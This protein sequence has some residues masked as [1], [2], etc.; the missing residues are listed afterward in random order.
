MKVTN[1]HFQHRKHAPF[2]FKG[3][4]F[5]LEPGKLHALHGKNG[6][7][8]SVLLNILSQNIEQE[9]VITGEIF[10]TSP[11]VLMNQRFDQAL[12]GQFTAL[13]NLAFARF[14]RFPSLFAP[15]RRG[16]ERESLEHFLEPFHIEPHVPV[17]N[18]SGGQRQ[19][20]TLLMQLQRETKV[21]L[22]DEPTAALDEE[23]AILV[24]EFLKTLRD[25]TL[26]V[27][28]HDRELVTKYTTGQHLQME[29]QGEGLRVIYQASS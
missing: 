29:L 13:E 12:A 15:L 19:I 9:A 25:V 18:L 7:G 6:I 2:F 20:L 14:G 23:N 16:K 1:L 26:L 3:L 11:A 5:Q 24:F 28:C 27:V 22:L 10:G 17:C 8:K 4:S 21:L